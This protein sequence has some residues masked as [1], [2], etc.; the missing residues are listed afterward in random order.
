MR[1]SVA[2][3]STGL[4]KA[5]NLDHVRWAVAEAIQA[6]ARLLVLP[7]ATMRAFG[8]PGS[9][10]SAVAEPLD[11]PFVDALHH[12]AREAN[13]IIVAGMFE[14]SPDP[15]RVFNT[16][17]AVGA[18]GVIG[19]YRKVHLYDA[20]GSCESDQI[21]PGSA[22]PDDLLVFP[23]E[24]FRVGIM[25]C[26]DLRFPEIAR[27]LVD[28]GATLLVEPAHWL[29]GPGKADVW[30]TLL[31]ARAIENTAYIAASAKAA[32]ECTGYTSI[33]DPRGVVLATLNGSERAVLTAE[34]DAGEVDE[35]RKVLPLLANRR[36]RVVER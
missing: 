18:N 3:L 30:R 10:L 13:L 28:H 1:V 27:V 35:T 5:D 16:I 8:D 6:R 36:Y 34:I 15:G 4:D 17:V 33:V 23:V 29:A 14:P 19:T 20:L 22:H 24:D 25:N 2:Q 21:S 31:A 7:E 12:G 32:P 11:G 26:Y 9:D